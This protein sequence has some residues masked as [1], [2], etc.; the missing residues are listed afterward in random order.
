MTETLRRYVVR[1]V[2]FADRYTVHEL[3]YTADDAVTQVQT[4]GSEASRV[5][6]VEPWLKSQHGAWKGSK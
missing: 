1:G 3:A 4:R 5:Q 6:D 2:Y